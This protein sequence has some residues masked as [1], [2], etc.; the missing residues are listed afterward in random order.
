MYNIP[1]HEHY[2]NMTVLLNNYNIGLTCWLY[3]VQYARWCRLFTFTCTC[4]KYILLT[5]NNAN[6]CNSLSSGHLVVGGGPCHPQTSL[7]KIHM[8]WMWPCPRPLL[9]C[10]QWC[11]QCHLHSMPRKE[12]EMWMWPQTHL[13]ALAWQVDKYGK[14]P[15]HHS[16]K[17]TCENGKAPDILFLFWGGDMQCR[18]WSLEVWS[19]WNI[20][21]TMSCKLCT[22]YLGMNTTQIW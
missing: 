10:G 22:P 13:P 2:P 20:L 18:N 14:S 4:W 15:V 6:G 8:K 11:G 12:R 9:F 21:C 19:M 5:C 7:R 1:W 3:D 16:Q 17:R